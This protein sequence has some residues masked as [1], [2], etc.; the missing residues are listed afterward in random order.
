MLE[1]LVCLAS[2]TDHHYNVERLKNYLSRKSL[3]D[4]DIF[5]SEFLRSRRPPSVVYRL[6]DWIQTSGSEVIEAATSASLIQLCAL[7]LTT[8]VRTLR[9][10]TTRCLVILGERH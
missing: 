10:R 2:R 6:L 9:D 1:T 3:I 8:T 7:F 4:R 5:W